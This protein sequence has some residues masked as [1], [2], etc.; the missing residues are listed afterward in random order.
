M[1]S[2]WPGLLLLIQTWSAVATSWHLAQQRAPALVPVGG[3]EEGTPRQGAWP[4]SASLGAK[5]KV[6]DRA[7]LRQ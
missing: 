7:A 4:R 6:G 5:W 3:T 2:L 1:V